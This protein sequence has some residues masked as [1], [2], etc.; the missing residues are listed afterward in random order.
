MKKPAILATMLLTVTL[1]LGALGAATSMG[2]PII[3]HP[4]AI[5]EAESLPWDSGAFSTKKGYYSSAKLVADVSSIL[6]TESEVLVRMETL[7][8]AAVYLRNDE[9]ES[10][11]RTV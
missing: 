9:S 6:K 2:P 8:R 5:G 7:R 11:R 1:G 10:L 3:C 4:I